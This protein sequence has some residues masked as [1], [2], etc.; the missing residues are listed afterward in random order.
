MNVVTNMQDLTDEDL[1]DTSR[2]LMA[3]LDHRRAVAALHRQVEDD[4]RAYQMVAGI[5][6]TRGKRPDGTWPE[7]VQPTGV[8]DAYLEGSHVSHNG[9][10]WLSLTPANVWEP[11]VS[12]WRAEATP[13][14]HGDVRPADWV[15]PTG[16]HDA[17]GKGDRVTFHGDVWES[18]IDA[19]V[20]KPDV[21]P[22]GWRKVEQ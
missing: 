20:W 11:G 8:Q 3:E 5:T 7:W 9:K 21:Y 19:N 17:Y 2:A 12:G 18:T 16:A 4:I 13:D 15:Q 22:D 1:A 14:G 10:V 6:S